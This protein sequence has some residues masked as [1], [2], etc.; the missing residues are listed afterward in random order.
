[1]KAVTPPLSATATADSMP[2][3]PI[4]RLPLVRLLLVCGGVYAAQGI[5]GG[6]TYQGLPAVLRA[7]NVPLDRIGLVFLA[8]LPWV[9]KLLWAPWIER[10]RVTA[11]NRRRS[12]SIV[13]IGQCLSAMTLLAI[14]LAGFQSFPLLLTLV[15]F[16]ATVAATVDIACDGFIVEQLSTRNRGWGNTAQMGGAYIGFVVGGGLF[17]WLS[18]AYGWFGG[19]AAMALFIVLLM[20]PALVIAEPQQPC[21]ERQHRPSLRFALARSEVRTG[22]LTLLLF[23]IGIRVVSGLEGPFLIDRGLDLKMV[24]L[25]SGF[26]G[27]AAGFLGCLLGGFVVGRSGASRA[28][29]LAISLQAFLLAAFLVAVNEELAT[30][31]VLV[32]LVLTK[33]VVMGF[34]FVAI[35]SLMMGLTSLRQAGVDFTIFQCVDAGV[36]ALGGFGASMLAYQFG[37]AGAIGLAFAVS[38]TA[39]LILP[40]VLLRRLTSSVREVAVR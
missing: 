40:F 17:L 16:L 21:S 12:R 32:V 35:Y 20:L 15:L 24:G 10:L 19:T 1:M 14:A 8:M 25:L 11:D 31:N 28:T 34:G 3:E 39:A 26:G 9:L 18:A 29:T 30:I 38:G 23:D 33:S 2:V 36:A 37:Y 7:N 22:I 13:L 6:L 5:I 27:A 4:R